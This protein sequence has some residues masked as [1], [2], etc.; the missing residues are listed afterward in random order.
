MGI[1][2][3][4][5]GWKEIMEIFFCAVFHVKAVFYFPEIKVLIRKYVIT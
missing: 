3:I 2:V 4:L 1:V 5:I